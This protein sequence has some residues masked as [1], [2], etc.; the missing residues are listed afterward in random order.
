MDE[1]RKPLPSWEHYWGWVIVFARFVALGM[2]LGT[3]KSFGVLMDFYIEHL[4]GSAAKMGAATALF[5][6]VIYLTG[7]TAK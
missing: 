5:L 1:I 4:H 7:K 6:T 2:L 3:Y